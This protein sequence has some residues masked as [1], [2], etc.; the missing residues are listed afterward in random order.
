MSYP[1]CH[2]EFSPPLFFSKFYP[3]L[4]QH[5]QLVFHSGPGEQLGHILCRG[6]SQCPV[7]LLH[8]GDSNPHS[9]NLNKKYQSLKDIG[10]CAPFDSYVSGYALIKVTTLKIMPAVFVCLFVVVV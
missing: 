5:Y 7:S 8:Y 3:G 4:V 6:L 9:R 10:H 2:V 1:F